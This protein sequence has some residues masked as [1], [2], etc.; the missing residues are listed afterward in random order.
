M[1]AQGLSVSFVVVAALA[2]LV[3]VLGAAFLMGAFSSQKTSASMEQ[4][5]S[6]CNTLCSRLQAAMGSVDCTTRCNDKEKCVAKYAWDQYNDFCSTS[7][8]IAGKSTKC[9]DLVSCVVTD[10]YGN[11]ISISCS[12]N[13]EPT[14]C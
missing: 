1:K 5:K 9:K 7:F 8:N 11:Q 12:E 13:S 4:A 6:T 3:L 14:S 2:I 10:A